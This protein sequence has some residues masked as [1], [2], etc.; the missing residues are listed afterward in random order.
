MAV[1][2]ARVASGRRII[3]PVGGQKSGPMGERSNIYPSTVLELLSLISRTT[4][5]AVRRRNDLILENLL[6]RQQLHDLEGR[7]NSLPLDELQ[8]AD[9][10]DAVVCRA[11]EESGPLAPCPWCRSTQTLEVSRRPWSAPRSGRE[12]SSARESRALH[13][14]H[15]AAAT[16][17]TLGYS[18]VSVKGLQEPHG[19]VVL[20]DLPNSLMSDLPSTLGT[21]GRQP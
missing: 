1:G 18:A 13:R 20:D 5:S 9:V 3:A 4:R 16:A 8:R 15:S 12:S 21:A 17:E 19:K 11:P 7:A 6:L 10:A 2:S 14:A